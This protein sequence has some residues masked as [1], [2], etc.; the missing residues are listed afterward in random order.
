MGERET[1]ITE[2]RSVA[3]LSNATVFALS[4]PPGPAPISTMPNAST[5]LSPRVFSDG[6]QKSGGQSTVDDPVV[7]RQR[8]L[9]D[10]ADRD[11][12]VFDHRLFHDARH[13]ENG[14]FTGILDGGEVLDV[15]HAHVG[16]RERTSRYLCRCQLAGAGLGCQLGGTLVDSRKGCL[17]ASRMTG[18]TSPCSRATARPR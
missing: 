14:A 16:N 9:H 7:R 13:C 2:P 12:V 10:G 8:H 17:S 1:A 6:I 18:T 15:Q 5:G 4:Y 3:D 11:L